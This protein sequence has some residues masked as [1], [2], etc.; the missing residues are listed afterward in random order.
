M[1]DSRQLFVPQATCGETRTNPEKKPEA[2][3]V[4]VQGGQMCPEF[5]LLKFNNLFKTSRS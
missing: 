3:G 1:V 4:V 2:A 5:R